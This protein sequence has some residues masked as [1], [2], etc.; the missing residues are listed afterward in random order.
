[1]VAEMQASK[2][3]S[4][5]RRIETRKDFSFLINTIYFKSQFHDKKDWN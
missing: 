2:A 3:N 5:I 1:M 4:T